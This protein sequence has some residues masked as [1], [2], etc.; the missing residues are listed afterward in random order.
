MVSMQELGIEGPRRNLPGWREENPLKLSVP[1]TLAHLVGGHNG[2]NNDQPPIVPQEQQPS[3]LRPQIPSILRTRASS[4]SHGGRPRGES[5]SSMA[6]RVDFSLGM[7]D[8]ASNDV[9]GDVYDD[10]SRSRIPPAVRLANMTE[11]ERRIA[12]EY[13][14]ETNG[15]KSK[16]RDRSNSNARTTSTDIPTSHGARQSM[17]SQGTSTHRNRFMERI[18]RPRG[19][20]VDVSND[21]EEGRLDPRTATI[22]T[23]GGDEIPQASR[24]PSRVGRSQTEDF[25]SRRYRR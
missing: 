20:S 4:T 21:M 22:T 16:S 23:G 6:R 24:S 3:S 18:G 12:E 19:S 1:S 9:A 8:M 15:K 13:E 2:N 10:R 7:R 25:A 11:S 5:V 17:D 14:E